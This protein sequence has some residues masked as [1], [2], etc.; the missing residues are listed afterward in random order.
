MTCAAFTCTANG[1][2]K[3]LGLG[4]EALHKMVLPVV[5]EDGWFALKFLSAAFQASHSNPLFLI[6]VTQING[7]SR[8]KTGF[9]EKSCLAGGINGLN[10]VTCSDSGAVS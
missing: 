10:L 8:S 2:S 1:A 3:N 5:P 9:W 4:I 6:S 7:H